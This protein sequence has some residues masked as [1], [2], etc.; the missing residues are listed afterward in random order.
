M[1]LCSF[2]L[3]WHQPLWTGKQIFSLIVPSGVNVE[4]RSNNHPDNENTWMSPGDTRVRIEDGN[5]V[6]GIIDKRTLGT[7][8]GSLVH[9]LWHEKGP[10]SAR[11]FLSSVQKLVNYWLQNHSFSVGIGDTIA[12]TSALNEIERIISTAKV[13]G[14]EGVAFGRGA[15]LNILRC[16]ERGD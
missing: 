14:C 15:Q 11:L 12:E 4:R 5:V 9:V 7:S 3:S 8:G 13:C 10:N 6:M 16:A 1:V 2:S